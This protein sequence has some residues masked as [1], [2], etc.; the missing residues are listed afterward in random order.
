MGSPSGKIARE[1]RAERAA[2]VIADV[3]SRLD[4]PAMPA[5]PSFAQIAGTDFADSGRGPDLGRHTEMGVG[6]FLAVHWSLGFFGGAGAS[7]NLGGV[8]PEL[9][10]NL[11]LGGGESRGRNVR[12]FRSTASFVLPPWSH[13]GARLCSSDHKPRC[14]ADY[15]ELVRWRSCRAAAAAE[16]I[17]RV[18]QVNISA[19]VVFAGA[20]LRDIGKLV[21]LGGVPKSYTRLLK[22]ADLRH[23]PLLPLERASLGT[24]HAAVGLQLARRWKWSA[25][26]CDAIGFHHHPIQL[27]FEIS[28]FGPLVAVVQIADA[29]STRSQSIG[30]PDRMSDR[31]LASVCER[32]GMTLADVEAISSDCDER[33][34]ELMDALS[35]SGERCAPADAYHGSVDRIAPP[36]TSGGSDLRLLGDLAN[37]WSPSDDESDVCGHIARFWRDFCG[38]DPVAVFA[39]ND[40]GTLV[41]C[42]WL[43]GDTIS[44][45]ALIVPFAESTPQATVGMGLVGPP[46][47]V[48]EPVIDRHRR[49]LGG[50]ETLMLSISH[51]G[52][53]IGGVLF[54]SDARV[55]RLFAERRA[56]I[57]TAAS[58]FGALLSQTLRSARME[59]AAGAWAEANRSLHDSAERVAQE[60]ALSMIAELSAGA[61]HEMNTPLANISGR[62]QALS[63]EADNVEDLAVFNTIR[64]H[65]DECSLIIDE[66]VAFAKPARPEP[67]R[68]TLK[69]WLD[70]NR[71][72]WVKQYGE[73]RI[74]V[75]IAVAEAQV[76]F[77]AD[78]EQIAF[79]L[80]AVVD[81][82]VDAS[83]RNKAVV[84]INSPSAATDETVMLAL[85]D[86]G[87]GMRW[88]VLERAF[89]PFYSHRRAGRQRGLG[90]STARRLVEIN[91]GRLWI[92]STPGEGTTVFVELPARRP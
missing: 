60:R 50:S 47:R 33:S 90:L 8:A 65:A 75:D 18:S 48:A 44:T 42:A 89:D 79:A 37:R 35:G 71:R 53:P 11:S 68:V 66:L 19:D 24:D 82:A 84:V 92:E 17:G 15:V 12:L 13:S 10:G 38:T 27:V 57:E 7:S 20:L 55:S 74:S 5:S 30:R 91:R 16:A 43:V 4:G 85:A 49:V 77:W 32:V 69:P 59:R 73:G 70:A 25:A 52:S 14:L 88:D 31:V 36:D 9:L 76:S 61:A 22:T 26:L 39:S 6:A 21:L 67:S 34:R 72:H 41:H 28:R 1:E 45:E 81:N 56:M 78:A 87:A 40:R 29:I 2:A 63:D 83:D 23:E 51:D 80:A 64:R 58:W 54:K 62:V 86:R 46:S 3:V